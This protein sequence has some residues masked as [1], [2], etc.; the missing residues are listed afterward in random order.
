[1]WS[2][3]DAEGAIQIV[4]E[5]DFVCG[6]H[7]DE[8]V[9]T[10][11]I[12]IDGVPINT[13]SNFSVSFKNLTIVSKSRVY[14]CNTS[15]SANTQA[16]KRTKVLKFDS[17]KVVISNRFECLEDLNINRAS[18]ALFQCRKSQDN[19][20]IINKFSNNNDLILYNVPTDDSGAMP[21]QSVNMT[22]ATFYTNCG[23]VNV[24]ITKGYDNPKYMG[25][26]S[27]FNDQNRLKVYFD[28]IKGSTQVSVGDILQAEFEISIT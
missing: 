25:Y 16:F 21:E 10:I 18:L 8:K 23:V 5:D 15:A 14:H 11:D 3:S 9:E 26:I 2:N 20:I 17:N 19:T 28:Y 24:K 6:Y 27:N 22:Q 1:M 7:G 12:L 13:S 4:G